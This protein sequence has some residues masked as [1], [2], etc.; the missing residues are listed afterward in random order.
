[1]K[2]SR[3]FP[4]NAL[5]VF[6]A[7]ARLRNFTR[8]GEELGMTQTAVTYQIKLLE[9]YLGAEVFIRRPRA[10]QLTETGESLIAKIT[11]AFALLTDAVTDARR[12]IGETLEIQSPPTFASHWLSRHLGDFQ[13]RTPHLSVRLN[14]TMGP[15]GADAMPGD[16][17]IRIG[18]EPWDGLVCHHLLTLHY[19]P[20]LHPKLADSIGGMTEPADLLKLP[21]ISDTKDI[22]TG[23]FDAMGLDPQRIRHVNLNTFGALDLQANAAMSGHGVAMLSPFFFADELAS[24]RLIQPFENSIGDGKSYW[25]TY[26]PSRRNQPKIRAFKAW[27]EETLARDLAERD[28]ITFADREISPST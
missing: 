15:A 28:L 12:T 3:Q 23:W 6:E 1:M 21:W 25:L 26:A 2:L 11:D 18:P 5:R 4:L 22:W 19:T 9:D 13:N 10:L 17:A 20:M 7:V 14:R 8:A 16:V 27:I 24:G